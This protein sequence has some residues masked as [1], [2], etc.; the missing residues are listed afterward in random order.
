MITHLG[1]VG[2]VFVGQAFRN[3]LKTHG[4][5]IMFVGAVRE[6]PLHHKS[7]K[8]LFWDNLRLASPHLP[9]DHL[10]FFPRVQNKGRFPLSRARHRLVRPL[11][12]RAFEQPEEFP[13]SD[14]VAGT[15]LEAGQGRDR[16]ADFGQHFL[17][18]LGIS[19]YLQVQGAGAPGLGWSAAVFPPRHNAREW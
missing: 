8:L 19:R 16:I 1:G 11:H 2:R 14:R 15:V 13:E 9:S 10:G 6:P 3:C 4:L 17:P 12:L 18:G 7:A 5:G